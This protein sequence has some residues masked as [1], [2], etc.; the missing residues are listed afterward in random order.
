MRDCFERHYPMALG[1]LSV[2]KALDPRTIT[3]GEVGRLDKGSS[4]I[5]VAVLSIALAF[6]LAVADLLTSHTPAI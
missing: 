5:L 4:Q 3:D 1:F 2:I 6:F